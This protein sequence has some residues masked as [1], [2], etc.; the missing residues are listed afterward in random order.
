[1]ISCDQHDYL[2]IACLYGYR[3]NVTTRDGQMIVGQ[4]KDVVTQDNR[5]YLILLCNGQ[6]VKIEADQLKT[7]TVLSQAMHFGEIFF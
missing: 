1:M 3:L 4:A 7:L 5:E 6:R 2:E